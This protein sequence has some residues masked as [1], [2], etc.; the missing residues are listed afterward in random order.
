MCGLPPPVSPL[1]I[2][3]IWKVFGSECNDPRVTFP[4][5]LPQTRH[6]L[7]AVDVR[8]T[9]LWRFVVFLDQGVTG[10]TVY[11][12]LHLIFFQWPDETGLIAAEP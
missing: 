12:C 11:Y 3:N 10:G 1:L 7:H 2:V 8:A 6:L 9:Q 4:L 5:H